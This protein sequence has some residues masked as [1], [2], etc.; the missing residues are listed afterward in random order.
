[1]KTKTINLSNGHQYNADLVV[2]KDE[3]ESNGKWRLFWEDPGTGTGVNEQS[4]VTGQP[5][6]CTMRDAIAYGMRRYGI[7]AI[8]ANW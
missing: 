7:R 2:F 4:T 1:M 6:F 3:I 8:R 5:F